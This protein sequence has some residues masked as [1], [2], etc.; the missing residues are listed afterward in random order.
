MS[1]RLKLRDEDGKWLQ[2]FGNNEYPNN[3]LEWVNKKGGEVDEDGC[4]RD[5]EVKD[6]QG[7]LEQIILYLQE[8]PFDVYDLRFDNEYNKE[9]KWDIFTMVE[10]YRNSYLAEIPTILDKFSNVIERR[11]DEGKGF[12]YEI[13]EGK[14]L[15]LSRY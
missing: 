6:L 12:V 14:K 4:F 3:L 1:D 8:L 9:R 10:R 7:F 15:Y 11:F 2:V 5:F 13:K